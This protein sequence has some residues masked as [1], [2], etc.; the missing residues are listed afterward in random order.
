VVRCTAS[1]AVRGG[2]P[3]PAALRY[4]CCVIPGKSARTVS[5]LNMLAPLNSGLWIR[6]LWTVC[7][8]LVIHDFFFGRANLF[9]KAGKCRAYLRLILTESALNITHAFTIVAFTGAKIV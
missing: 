4:T 2:R 6:R 8:P 9:D 1:S 3:T 7:W 5:I